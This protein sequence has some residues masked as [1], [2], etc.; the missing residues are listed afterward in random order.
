[1]KAN[2]KLRRSGDAILKERYEFLKSLRA[3]GEV[4]TRDVTPIWNVLSDL[5][6]TGLVEN[7]SITLHPVYGFFYLKGQSLKGLASNWC[8]RE[9]GKDAPFARIF[10]GDEHGQGTVEFLDAWPTAWPELRV[11]DSAV[12]FADYYKGAGPPHDSSAPDTH[13][14]LA[15]GPTK[16]VLALKAAPH[17]CAGDVETAMDWLVNALSDDGYGAKTGS[18]FG[19]ME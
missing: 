4:C 9:P 14:F 5:S 17:A 1:V 2:E 3:H 15:A 11:M 8:K 10:G 7:G 12:H 6:R 16:F 18:A 13:C 19:Y